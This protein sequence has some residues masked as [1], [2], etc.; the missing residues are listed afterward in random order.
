MLTKGLYPHTIE[1]SKP[2]IKAFWNAH[3]VYKAKI[4]QERKNTVLRK[5]EKQTAHISKDIE[6]MKQQVN[7]I[8]NRLKR[9]IAI[10]L[11]T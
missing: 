8:T 7:E 10:L 9:W 5:H 11:T 1:I 4:E 6:K 2:T 3:A